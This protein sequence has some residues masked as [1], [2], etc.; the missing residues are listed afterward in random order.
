MV[1]ISL[2]W[3]FLAVIVTPNPCLSHICMMFVTKEIHVNCGRIPMDR[4]LLIGK[5]FDNEG[6]YL[7][8][9]QVTYTV[10]RR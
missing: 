4:M 1:N 5:T 6:F 10:F 8:T 3:H 2:D 9:L 7:N